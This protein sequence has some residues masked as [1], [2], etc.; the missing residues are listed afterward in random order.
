MLALTGWSFADEPKVDTPKVAP[1]SESKNEGKENIFEKD[2]Q[3][4]EAKDKEHPPQPGQV[5]FVGSSS[6]RLWDLKKSFPKLDALNRGFGGSQTSDAVFYAKR[7]VTAYKPR[8]V[9]F[10]SGDNDLGSGKSPEQVAK[11]VQAF[12]EAVRADMREVP[13]ILLSIKPS[14][15]RE[16]LIDKQKVAN[17]LIQDN[18]VGQKN[19]TFIDVVPAMLTSEGKPRPEIFRDDQL[20]MNDEGYK[21]WAGLLE[22]LVAPSPEVK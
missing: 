11:D 2:I 14:V 17:K 8:M 21:I 4:F 1:A 15:K 18:A 9:V 6:V 13:I 10:Y 22:K 20:H 7:I 19:V 12:V 16:K 5:V 3:A